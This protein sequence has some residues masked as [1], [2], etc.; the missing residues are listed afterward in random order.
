MILPDSSG[1]V[2]PA[3]HS[4]ARQHK[5]AKSLQMFNTSTHRFPHAPQTRKKYSIPLPS[6]QSA[7]AAN[8]PFTSFKS[9]FST[10]GYLNHHFHTERAWLENWNVGQQTNELISCGPAAPGLEQLDPRNSQGSFHPRK[11]EKTPALGSAGGEAVGGRARRRRQ[12]SVSFWWER[13]E[14]MRSLLLVSQPTS[15]PRRS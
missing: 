13:G 2:T 15:C 1:R 8:I 9:L 12:S 11:T 5:T 7:I 4:L 3:P 6:L 14:L 10:L